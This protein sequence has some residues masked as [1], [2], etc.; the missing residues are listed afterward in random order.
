M[1]KGIILFD[2]DGFKAP[3]IDPRTGNYPP[4]VVLNPTSTPTPTPT[5]TPTLT[6]T[7]TVTPTP[8]QTLT[9]SPTL[10]ATQTPTLT[11][12]P[13]L[14]ATNTPTLT[15]SPTLTAT[16]TP[17]L[18][19]SPTLT[20]TVTPTLTATRTVTPTPTQTLTSTP[21][22][23]STNT[24]TLTAT[25]T[26]TPTPTPT[27]SPSVTLTPTPTPTKTPTPTPSAAAAISASLVFDLDAANYSAVPTNGSTVNGYTLGVSNAGSSITWNSANG[28]TFAK[29][30]STGTDVIYGGPN[31]V[32]G[33]SYT[34][35]MAYKLSATSAGRLLNTQ[36]E[37]SKDWMM[38]AYNGNPNAFYP[39]FTVNLPGSGADTVWHFAW[40]TWNSTT[41]TGQLW[42]ATNTAPTTYTYTATSAGGGGF[43][44]LRLFSRAAGSEVQSGN[45][46]FVK[47]YNGV[48]T[49][50]NIQSLHATYKTR[51]GY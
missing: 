43:N 49:L 35:F 30:N 10:T 1:A 6:A 31:Y 26:T 20:Q 8:T 40:A 36:N 50:A 48:L 18:T 12:S 44:Q 21:T 32:T 16:T 3:G 23:T 7:Q 2:S 34:V 37:S 51:M 24:P 25:R 39:N 38:G 9:A 14:T 28:G 47:V 33:Q 42:I 22:L 27:G 5:Q 4:Q 15:A 19:A 11:A 41:T 45:I 17:T 13:T 46:A 29:S